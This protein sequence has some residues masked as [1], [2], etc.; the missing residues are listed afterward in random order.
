M[1]RKIRFV[2][3]G[4]EHHPVSM[5]KARFYDATSCCGGLCTPGC[6]FSLSLKIQRKAGEDFTFVGEAR[7]SEREANP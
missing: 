6:A 2:I 7:E 1:L 4:I 3:T 5:L